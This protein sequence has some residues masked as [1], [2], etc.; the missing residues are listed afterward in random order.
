[1]GPLNY[2]HLHYFWIVAREGGIAAASRKL[3]VGRPAISAQLKTLETAIGARLFERRG[4]H[5]DLTD[6][7]RLVL[8]YAE[9]I[10]AKGE[11][12][13]DV[14]RGRSPGRRSAL[15]VGIADAMMKL[16]AFRVLRPTLA[17]EARTTLVCSEGPPADLFGALAVH[18]LDLVL[19]DVAP[20]PDLEVR[21]RVVA[22]ENGGV[23]L[24]GSPALTARFREG[25]PASLSGAEL[26]LPSRQSSIRRST[27]AWLRDLE[28]SPVVAAE[29]DDSALLKIFG[30][31]GLGLFPAPLDM[32]E[33]LE[34]R[35]GVEL[36]GEL[37][38][39]RARTYAVFPDRRHV[40]PLVETMFLDPA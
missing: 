7:G 30:E 26:L 2:H 19:A 39:A 24:F 6:I 15:R 13:T 1:M 23:G 22:L 20:P 21:V 4:R 35:Y 37:D 28:L 36:L 25:F 29:F 32:R 5:L 38:G 27:D 16:E 33:E 10:F 18:E 31:A 34:S 3:H 8:D 9:E 40:H 11:E 17:G 12:L 14:L